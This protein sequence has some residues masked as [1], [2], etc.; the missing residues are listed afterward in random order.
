MTDFQWITGCCVTL[1]L[2]ILNVAARDDFDSESSIVHIARQWIS[3]SAPFL[4]FAILNLIVI[5]KIH[6]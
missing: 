1:L 4:L 6:V 2:G 3:A 5:G